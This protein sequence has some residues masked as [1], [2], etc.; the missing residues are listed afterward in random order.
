MSLRVEQVDS[1]AGPVM[2]EVHVTWNTGD[3]RMK[4]FFSRLECDAYAKTVLEGLDARAS[5]HTIF[6]WNHNDTDE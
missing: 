6:S 2:F 4:R 3:T 5:R 1:D